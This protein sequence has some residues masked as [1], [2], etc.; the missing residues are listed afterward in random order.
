MGLKPASGKVDPVRIWRGETFWERREPNS[1]HTR[2]IFFL[3][4]TIPSR[5]STWCILRI[6]ID[7]VKLSQLPQTLLQH[8]FDR[9][10]LQGELA[11]QLEETGIFLFQLL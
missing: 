4:T 8:L 7:R 9:R 10:V 6:S 5:S 2:W 3:L 11:D 1:L